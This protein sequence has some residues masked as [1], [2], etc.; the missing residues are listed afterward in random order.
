[1]DGLLDTYILGDVPD[2]L[3]PMVRQLAYYRGFSLEHVA[4]MLEKTLFQAHTWIVEELKPTGLIEQDTKSHPYAI[5]RTAREL[6]Q[7][8]ALTRDTT[9]FRDTHSAI[10]GHLAAQLALPT[11]NWHR[12]VVEYLYHLTS[13]LRAMRRTD[14]SM[15]AG[16]LSARLHDQLMPI[17]DGGSVLGLMDLLETDVELGALVEDLQR[18]LYSVLQQA[19]EKK[20]K[21]LERGVT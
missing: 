7:N 3:K 11:G 19:V 6:F 21:D 1:M 5:D 10:A 13:E 16:A 17:T 18:D 12:Y 9:V 8:V 4:R 2:H 20:A 14:R 15:D